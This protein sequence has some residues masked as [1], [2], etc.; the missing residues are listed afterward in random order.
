MPACLISDLIP[1]RFLTS[2]VITNLFHFRLSVSLFLNQFSH[3]Q[4]GSYFLTKVGCTFIVLRVCEMLPRLAT[5][6]LGFRHTKLMAL[7]SRIKRLSD[8]PP[9][10]EVR[11]KAF[12]CDI[13][14]IVPEVSVRICSEPKTLC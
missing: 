5:Q 11:E 14:E 13:C 12:F 8:L 6:P 1:V 4:L 10:S 7:A 2:L 3:Y 9:R